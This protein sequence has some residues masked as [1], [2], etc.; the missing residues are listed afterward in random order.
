M[1]KSTIAVLVIG[2]AAGGYWWAQQS[3]TT[4]P[5]FPAGAGRGAGA[6]FVTTDVIQ[7]MPL[8]QSLTLVGNLQAR[9]AINV[10]SEVSGKIAHI[11]VS[12]N[13][14]VEAGQL[15]VQLDNLQS[16]ASLDE[17]IAYHRDEMRKLTEYAKLVARGA[18]TQTQVDAQQSA[19][20][21]AKARL[22]AAQKRFDDHA[23]KAPFSGT[24]GLLDISA[25]QLVKDSEQLLTLDDLSLMQLDLSV[26]EQYLSQI[27]LGDKVTAQSQAWGNEDFYGEIA[28]I[29][30]RV[31]QDSLNIRVRIEFVNA[32]NKLKPGMLMNAH[33]AFAPQEMAVIP[34]QGLEYSG[35]RRY[36]YVID[37]ENTAHRTEVKLGGRVGNQVMVED[38]VSIGDKIVVQG[39]VNIRDGARVD[40]V[41]A[42]LASPKKGQ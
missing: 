38:G 28:A 3:E 2:L 15:L 35:T 12:E 9:K 39:L 17:A 42:A 6:V 13:S 21:I 16:K 23:V 32:E 34:V 22:D 14:N 18:V 36:V 40:D 26:P 41:N 27:M 37:D 30:S 29:D 7:S 19:V 31:L 20:D 5:S 33:M 8:S 4:P 10:A 25:G 1:K 24:I 11:A